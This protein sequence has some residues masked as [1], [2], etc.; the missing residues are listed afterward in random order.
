MILVLDLLGV[1]YMV[2]WRMVMTAEKL[3]FVLRRFIAGGSILD[4]TRDYIVVDKKKEVTLADWE[5]AAF[6]GISIALRT[7][8]SAD[9][10]GL[11][12][13]LKPKIRDVLCTSARN[14]QKCDLEDAVEEVCLLV[15]ATNAQAEMRTLVEDAVASKWYKGSKRRHTPPVRVTHQTETTLSSICLICNHD[16]TALLDLVKHTRCHMTA[17]RCEGVCDTCD[18]QGSPY[19]AEEDVSQRHKGRQSRTRVDGAVVV[20]VKKIGPPTGSWVCCSCRQT[21]NPRFCPDRC[22]MDGHYRCISCYVYR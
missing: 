7:Q 1:M 19:F 21:D 13:T 5:S 16:H 9:Y 8:E 15:G 14:L 6:A 3:R 22:P 10:A 2:P 11:R 17:L 20:D 12:A 4:W 18:E